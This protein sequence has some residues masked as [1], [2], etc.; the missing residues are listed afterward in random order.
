[1]ST[2]S[3]CL[4]LLPFPPMIWDDCEWWDGTIDLS[5]GVGATLSVTP[6]NPSVNRS[7]SDYQAKALTFLLERGDEVFAEVLAAVRP[8]YERM[9]PKYRDF[10]GSDFNLLMPTLAAPTDLGRL[11]DL[12]HVHIH[13]WTKDGIGYVGLQ[14]GCTWDQEHGLGALM[15]LDRV[16]DVGCADVSFAW[17]PAEGDDPS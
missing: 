16:V 4:K 6:Y 8:Y 14:F 1:M 3:N 5:F 13:P 7:P 11:I 10:L 17:A 12:R 2:H 15:H 9:R